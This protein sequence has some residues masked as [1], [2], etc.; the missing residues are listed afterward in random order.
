[1]SHH[2]SASFDST[3]PRVKAYESK[4]RKFV[5]VD[6]GELEGAVGLLTDIDCTAK[7]K[8]SRRLVYDGTEKSFKYVIQPGRAFPKNFSKIL[9]IMNKVQST[10]TQLFVPL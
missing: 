3:I 4:E 7:E 5:L 9:E 1:M 8:E 6:I 10:P 2:G